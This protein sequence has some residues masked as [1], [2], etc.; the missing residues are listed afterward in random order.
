MVVLRTVS[1]VV[2]MDLEFWNETGTLKGES[3]V[4]KVSF[5]PSRGKWNNILRK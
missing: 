1:I 3:S 5:H 2:I 4:T